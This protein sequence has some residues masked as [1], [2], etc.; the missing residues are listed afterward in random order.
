METHSLTRL[1]APR[2]GFLVACNVEP[3]K[4]VE[5][6]MRLVSNPFSPVTAGHTTPRETLRLAF[7]F[8]LALS[9][10]SLVFSLA[11]AVIALPIFLVSTSLSGTTAILAISSAKAEYKGLSCRRSKITA[12]TCWASLMKSS[13]VLGSAFVRSA[14]SARRGPE[15]CQSLALITCIFHR[16]RPINSPPSETAPKKSA[17]AAASASSC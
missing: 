7:F 6:T 3:A 5:R 14:A 8:P 10:A 12:E 11:T 13:L 16:V 9:L 4:N 1:L 17:A 15:M 2:A